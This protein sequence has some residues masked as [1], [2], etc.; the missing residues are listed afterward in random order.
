MC[1]GQQ[2][3]SIAAPSEVKPEGPVDESNAPYAAFPGD[4]SPLSPGDHLPPCGGGSPAECQ[5]DLGVL[6][7]TS[8]PM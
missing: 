2:H 8:T 4:Q 7:Q 1:D 5:Q 3:Q 6:C